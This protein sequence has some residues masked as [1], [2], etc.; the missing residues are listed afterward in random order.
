MATITT[1]KIINIFRSIICRFGVPYKLISDNGKQFECG[2]MKSLCDE[3][4]IQKSYSAVCHPR[5]G[6]IEAMNKIL[7]DI[8]KKKLEKAKGNW[9]DELPVVLLA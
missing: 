9:V 7:K 4:Q 2:K 6:R 8:I 5:N 3:L 1:Q